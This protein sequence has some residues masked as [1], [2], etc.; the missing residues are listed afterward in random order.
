MQPVGRNAPC[1]LFDYVK[2]SMQAEMFPTNFLTICEKQHAVCNA[3]NNTFIH[4]CTYPS[5]KFRNL[6]CLFLNILNSYKF[7]EADQFQLWENELVLYIYFLKTSLYL[8]N[9][10]Y[11]LMHQLCFLAR[12][13]SHS[14]V[15]HFNF[16]V[17]FIFVS[18][19][20]IPDFT[21]YRTSDSGRIHF[22][23]V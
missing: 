6:T 10:A 17:F 15:L 9:T 23:L 16:Q 4:F 5:K 19:S 7:T 20:S 2:N 13:C 1:E 3:V 18:D 14:C 12:T 21:P 22:F 11:V 8:A